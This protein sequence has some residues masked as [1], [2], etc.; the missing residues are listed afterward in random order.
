MRSFATIAD[1]EA[2]VGAHLGHSDWH[3]ITQEMIDTFADVTGDHQWIHVDVERARGG[4][5]RTPIAHGY[6]TL[7]LTSM[8]A[9]QVCRF[10][11]MR[12]VV[13]YGA[14]RA[15]F[16]APVPVG[17]WIRAGVEL[18]SIRSTPRGHQVTSR[19]TVDIKDGDRPAC[20]IDRITLLVPDIE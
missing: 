10:D 8:L 20:V 13:N 17:S 1:V 6:L 14:D 2:A 4:P 12:M 16:P 3:H 19:V 18:S 7:S 11:G 9:G 15:R 5:F